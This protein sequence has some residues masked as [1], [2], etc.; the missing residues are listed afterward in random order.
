MIWTEW[1]LW[2]ASGVNRP[3]LPVVF[4]PGRFKASRFPTS[5]HMRHRMC[6]RRRRIGRLRPGLYTPAS[7]LSQP[8]QANTLVSPLRSAAAAND[9]IELFALL[10]QPSSHLACNLPLT[11]R[12]GLRLLGPIHIQPPSRRSGCPSRLFLTE[13]A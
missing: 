8:L 2:A 11:R 10:T 12:V 5:A 3:S 4:V 9:I 13:E 1:L 7:P 6:F